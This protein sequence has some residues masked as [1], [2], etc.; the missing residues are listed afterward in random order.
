MSRTIMIIIEVIIALAA[1]ALMIT[2][3]INTLLR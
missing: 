1:F 2:Y 3:V